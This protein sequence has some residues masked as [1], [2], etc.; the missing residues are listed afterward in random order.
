M[1]FG[2][3]NKKALVSGSTAGIG[4]A[5]AMEL[6]AEGAA[7]VINGRTD[8]RVKSAIEQI[9]KTHPKADLIAAAADLGTAEGVRQMVKRVPGVDILVNN[10]GIFEPKPF[11]QISDEH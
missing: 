8:E 6:A 5:I 7:V 9:R 3:K 1:D 4:L 2:L 10:L 11:Q